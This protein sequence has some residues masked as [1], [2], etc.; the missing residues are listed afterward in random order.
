MECGIP[1]GE[2]AWTDDILEVRRKNR[3]IFIATAILVIGALAFLADLVWTVSSLPSPSSGQSQS[4]P[5]SGYDTLYA[6][7]GFIIAAVIAMV[8]L[9]WRNRVELRRRGIDSPATRAVAQS[10][11]PKFEMSRLRSSGRL[12][13]FEPITPH[14]ATAEPSSP[15]SVDSYLPPSFGHVSV[16]RS[17]PSSQQ[18]HAAR[19]VAIVILALIV[20]LLILFVIPIPIAFSESISSS[21]TLP[22]TCTQAMNLGSNAQVSGTFSSASG[23][24]VV[25]FIYTAASGICNEGKALKF[26]AA[27]DGSGTFS[28]VSGSGATYYFFATTVLPDTV[29]ISGTYTGALL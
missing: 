10:F 9:F 13:T 2:E 27:L 14:S 1:L 25:L 20:I 7:F 8:V 24:P 22:N 21:A 15:T 16:R 29:S 6:V 4:L 17:H 19:N 3:P 28:F 11:F 23:Q 26:S 18:S 5:P 12:D